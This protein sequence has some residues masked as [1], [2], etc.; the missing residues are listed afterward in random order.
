MGNFGPS[1]EID[2][3]GLAP[4]ADQQVDVNS[5]RITQRA[6]PTEGSLAE[7]VQSLIEN[8]TQRNVQNARITAKLNSERP[9]DPAELKQAGLAWKSNF[10]TR[11]LNTLVTKVTSRFPRSISSA[12]YLTSA[13]LAPTVENSD[14]KTNFYRLEHAKFLRGLPDWVEFVDAIANEDVVFGWTVGAALDED[15]IL[16]RPFRQD[17]VYVPVGTRQT[18]SGFTAVVFRVDKTPHEAFR[19]L[20]DAKV[21]A[22]QNKD[23]RWH[24]ERLAEAINGAIPENQRAKI[25]AGESARTLTDLSRQLSSIGTYAG[26]KKVLM[27][28]VVAV[29]LTGKV[30]HYILDQQ[31]RLLFEHLDRWE[32]ME[33]VVSP[34][35]FERGD[36]TLHGSKGLGRTAY[37]FA[38]VLDRARNDAVDRLQLSGKMIVKCPDNNRERFKMSVVG[39][40]IQLNQEATIEKVNIDSN[41]ESAMALDQMLKGLLDEMS[42]S[43]SPRTFEGRDR[44]TN[45]EVNL[46]SSREGEQV[47][48]TMSRFLTQFGAAVTQINKRILRSEKPEARAFLAK[49]A[50][51]LTP[52]EISDL[53][54]QPAVRVVE[55]LTERER[56]NTIIAA[57]ELQ[58]NPLVD[59][60]LLLTEKLSAQVS[61]DFA[62]R[63]MLPVNDPTVQQEQTRMQRLENVALAQGIP[64][65]VSPRDNHVTHLSEMLQTMSAVMQVLQQDPA[66]ASTAMASIQHVAEHAA[67]AAAS[68][69]QLPPEIEQ[70]VKLSAQLE[71]ELASG[72]VSDQNAAPP[73]ESGADMVG[74]GPGPA[75]AVP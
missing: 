71:Q 40:V 38:A 2:S 44:V 43:V 54:T 61:P 20:E 12:R 17:Q 62:K 31:R 18:P 26:T 68:K 41:V 74:G 19:L 53:M 46:L 16:P 50:E 28:H 1:T 7:F 13:N 47:D 59:Q 52:E 55:D 6:F 29:E 8:N 45:A 21:S 75:P 73:T 9:W 39:N 32:S 14:S 58:G 72:M 35:A 42:G 30:S 51:R 63:V 24:L 66:Q 49:L 48:N 15:D 56:Q 57:T 36:G 60:H 69:Q 11:P 4:D 65:P 10:T 27:Y 3:R 5:G 22:E 34:F 33:E 64:V 37:A 23:Q 25:Q 70:L 67:A